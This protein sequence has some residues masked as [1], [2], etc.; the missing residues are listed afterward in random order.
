MT[1]YPI[2]VESYNPEWP[3]RFEL[4]K[5]LLRGHLGALILEIHHVGSTA[6]PDLAAKS[7]IDLDV[8]LKD[9]SQLN[10]A[11]EQLG[12]LGYNYMGEMGITGRHAFTAKGAVN[13]FPHHLYICDPQSDGF[14]NH[15]CLRDFLRTNET[16]RQA[17]ADLKKQ[18]AESNAYDMDA[19]VQGK[20][21][22]ITGILAR[23]GFD[24]S[25]LNLIQKENSFDDETH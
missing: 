2:Q 14:K 5:E 24:D 11:I 19:Y 15:I 3:L 7:V 20:T 1:N 18:L 22:F 17:Y 12:Q 13:K 4:L 16:A 25:A 8:I 23:A 21:A 6:V 9:L 10:L